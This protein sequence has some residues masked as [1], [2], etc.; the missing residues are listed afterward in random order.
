VPLPRSSTSTP[1]AA[2]QSLTQT[3]GGGQ[4]QRLSVLPNTGPCL[5]RSILAPLGQ[6]PPIGPDGSAIGRRR[7]R[8]EGATWSS[9]WPDRRVLTGLAR[10]R[11]DQASPMKGTGDDRLDFVNE[12]FRSLRLLA[13][14]PHTNALTCVTCWC[15]VSVGLGARLGSS[16]SRRAGSGRPA[17]TQTSQG[18]AVRLFRDLRP[19]RPRSKASPMEGCDG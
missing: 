12:R 2:P 5:C 19:N 8:G 16:H 4:A 14:G 3:H 17:M 6:S 1:P 15:P 11:L 9:Q 13:F 10:S 18:P 7:R